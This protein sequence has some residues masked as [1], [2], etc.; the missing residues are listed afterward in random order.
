MIRRSCVSV[1]KKSCLLVLSVKA[2]FFS[3]FEYHAGRKTKKNEFAP[4]TVPIIVVV[5]VQRFKWLLA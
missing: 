1:K 3:W 4:I 2:F 5:C